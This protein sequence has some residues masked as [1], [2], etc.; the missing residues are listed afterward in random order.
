[1]PEN[2]SK[3]SEPQGTSSD[4]KDAAVSDGIGEAVG[5]GTSAL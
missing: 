1:M 5:A 2:Q 3:E 4:M